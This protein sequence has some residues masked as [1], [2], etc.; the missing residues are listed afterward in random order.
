M[1][2]RSIA[3]AP[4][5]SRWLEIRASSQQTTRIACARGGASMPQ[6]F[7]AASAIAQLFESGAR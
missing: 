7:S 5:P 4:S 6:T 1:A 2:P 3:Y